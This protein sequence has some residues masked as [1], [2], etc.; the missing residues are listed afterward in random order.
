MFNKRLFTIQCLWRKFLQTRSVNDRRWRP[1]RRVTT[2]RHDRYIHRSHLRD[3]FTPAT[4]SARQTRGIHGANVTAQ[5]IRNRFREVGLRSR[6]PRKGIILTPRHR[7]ARLRWA[8]QHLRFTRADWAH[9]LFVDET[10]VNMS[11]ADNRIRIYPRRGER[12]A[13]NC[14]VERDRYGGGSVMI[15][16]GISMHT[17]TEA[18]VVNGNLNARGYQDQIITPVLIPHFR[19]N[20]GMTLAQDNATCHTAQTTQQMLQN[21]NIRVLPWPARSPD[22]NPIEHLWDQLKRDI[23]ELPQPANLR[24]LAAVSSLLGE[25]SHKEKFKITLAQ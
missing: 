10:R 12:H 23:R 6:R 9:V 13:A 14:V 19:A 16:A 21:N 2:L 3:R 15:W 24:A 5:T 22:L 25:E 7:Q 8:T 1:K 4:I 18:I 11:N 17:K 20:R